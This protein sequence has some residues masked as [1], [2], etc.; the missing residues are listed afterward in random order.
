MTPL[1]T[2]RAAVL[3]TMLVIAVVGLGKPT[4]GAWRRMGR[5]SWGRGR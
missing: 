4:D 2:L 5:R 1:E 3:A